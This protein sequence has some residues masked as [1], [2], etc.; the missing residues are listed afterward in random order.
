MISFAF[1][2][3]IVKNWDQSNI[4]HEECLGIMLLCPQLSSTLCNHNTKMSPHQ[5]LITAATI[6]GK[7]VLPAKAGI[8]NELN[9]M[10][11]RV[12]HDILSV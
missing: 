7:T 6:Y 10:P 1:F 11:D 2:A 9:W 12:R 3:L 5:F 8:P 4:Y